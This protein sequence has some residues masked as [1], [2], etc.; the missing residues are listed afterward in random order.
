MGL[1]DKLF[2][3]KE[4]NKVEESTK[5][6]ET[7]DE[8]VPNHNLILK[9][10]NEYSESI[11]YDSIIEQS[12]EVEIRPKFLIRKT[13][14]SHIGDA[15]I[16]YGGYG[17]IHSFQ[18]DIDSANRL[19]TE[20]TYKSIFNDNLKYFD[21]FNFTHE[22]L[23]E[24]LNN[25]FREI[26]KLSDEESNI[27]LS[28]WCHN[29]TIEQANEVIKVLEYPLVSI[30]EK[31]DDIFYLNMLNK[32]FWG[33][34]LFYEMLDD[35]W[36]FTCHEYLKNHIYNEKEIA[37]KDAVKKI[38]C[39]LI[40]YPN[41]KF[42][43]YLQNRINNAVDKEVFENSI[44]DFKDYISNE[45]NYWKMIHTNNMFG[46]EFEDCFSKVGH[47]FLELEPFTTHSINYHEATFY[48]FNGFINGLPE[49]GDYLPDF[50]GIIHRGKLYNLDTDKLFGNNES[51]KERKEF[52]SDRHL[53]KC[54]FN[55]PIPPKPPKDFPNGLRFY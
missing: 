6:S 36:D 2:G 4:K 49:Y 35:T 50:N 19:V 38:L 43:E 16:V 33:D 8:I 13:I 26:F 52:W 37:V 40:K 51:L 44:K 53:L 55:K 47:L 9:E 45:Q 41:N 3:K 18:Y 39:R 17:D 48:N 34:A 12:E 21:S 30:I 27:D 32:D 5:T 23:Q 1:F 29:S 11:E 42:F 54:V 14:W 20:L 10:E 24:S 15:Y 7:L 28:L 31:E 46:K 25:K 22:G